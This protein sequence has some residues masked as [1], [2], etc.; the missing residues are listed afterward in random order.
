MT[1]PADVV[2][3]GPFTLIESTIVSTTT[4]INLDDIDA[5]KPHCF[6]GVQFFDDA[7]GETSASPTAGT[8]PFLIETVNTTPNLEAAP[9]ASFNTQNLKT[10]TWSGNTKSVQAMPSGITGAAFYRLVVTCNET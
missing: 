9:T 1:K 3:N 4:T 2:E 5:V 10:I 7:L 6:A 8:V